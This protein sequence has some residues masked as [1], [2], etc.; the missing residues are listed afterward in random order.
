MFPVSFSSGRSPASSCDLGSFLF[1]LERGSVVRGTGAGLALPPRLTYWSSFLAPT[2]FVEV[3][4]LSAQLAELPQLERRRTEP[5]ALFHALAPKGVPAVPPF[6]SLPYLRPLL[7]SSV[8]ASS[9]RTLPSFLH[10]SFLHPALLH[11]PLL[12]PSF[13]SHTTTRKMTTNGASR[14]VGGQEKWK[15][16]IIGALL[17]LGNR[18]GR[19]VADSS[20]VG[21]G[22]GNWCALLFSA[23]V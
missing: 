12:A 17:G 4:L 6:L 13:L 8:L 14:A 1:F 5:G 22:S 2:S 19:V 9:L 16:A 10:R 15:V 7:T 23:C 20:F 3:F 11:R 18:L 21:A